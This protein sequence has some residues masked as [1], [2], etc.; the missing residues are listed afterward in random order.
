M[1]FVKRTVLNVFRNQALEHNR[2]VRV[3]RKLAN[4]SPTDWTL[5]L[6]RH[7]GFRQVGDNCHISRENIFTDPAYT[8]IG[9][10]VWL[11]GAWVSGHDGSVIMMGQAYGIKLD[12]VGPVTFKDDVFIGRGATILPGVT[13]G[14][15]A[16]VGAG[17]V[18]SKDVP[19]NSVVAGNPARVIRTLDEHRDI[20]RKRSEAYPWFDLIEKREGGY[21]PKIEPELKRRRISYF[22]GPET[23]EES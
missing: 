7:G 5:Y 6:K 15:R 3:W 18:V 4:P 10:N 17:S 20:I 9:N 21:D 12:G 13:I 8:S 1:N 2:F 22:F 16:I 19:P 11:T 23:S 14:P